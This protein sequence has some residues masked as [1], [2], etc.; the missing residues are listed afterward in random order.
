MLG[1]LL[2]EFCVDG[3]NLRMTHEGEGQDGDGVRGPSWDMSGGRVDQKVTGSCV[4][5]ES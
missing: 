5:K 4:R 2:A 1:S 3:Q